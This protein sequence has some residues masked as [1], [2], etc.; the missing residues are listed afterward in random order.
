MFYWPVWRRAITWTNAGVLSAGVLWTNF[1]EIWIRVLSISFQK[2]H[3]KMSSAELAAILSGGDE[4]NHCV[5]FCKE[6]GH[7]Y[8]WY[9]TRWGWNKMAFVFY[10]FNSSSLVRQYFVLVISWFKVLR[11]WL[12]CTTK[13]LSILFETHMMQITFCQGLQCFVPIQLLYIFKKTIDRYQ[14]T[15]FISYNAP[16]RAILNWCNHVISVFE[17]VRCLENIIVSQMV[18]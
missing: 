6:H 3:L 7:M 1:N 11:L 2:M 10:H 16:V 9:S 14:L 17:D 12:L 5:Y 15:W 4:L 13:K 8:L 18:E